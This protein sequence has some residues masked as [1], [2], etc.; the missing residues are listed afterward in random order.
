MKVYVLLS[1]I[2]FFI[3]I[4]PYAQA[5]SFL[6]PVNEKY[7]FVKNIGWATW[8]EDTVKTAE[9]T[10]VDNRDNEQYEKGVKNFDIIVPDFVAISK[11]KASFANDTMSH[12]LIEITSSDQYDNTISEKADGT[13]VLNLSGNLTKFNVSIKSNEKDTV[14]YSGKIFLKN[15][16]V[17]VPIPIDIVIQHDVNELI[18]VNLIGIAIGIG[19][20]V[21]IANVLWKDKFKLTTKSP[22]ISTTLIVMIGIPSSVYVNT[23]FIGNNALDIVIAFAVGVIVFTKLI[24]PQDKP[25]NEKEKERPK[26]KKECC[27]SWETKLKNEMNVEL[28]VNNI[29]DCNMK[30]VLKRSNVEITSTVIFPNESCS[31]SNDKID[32]IEW[33]SGQSVKP[34]GKCKYTFNL[35][36]T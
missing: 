30:I 14:T 1:V 21:L 7:T 27:A 2:F 35:T 6:S 5:E 11:G 36:I 33:S 25:K 8:W 32:T 16:S 10:I 19:I 15:E 12:R 29:G 26:H 20:A 34:Q 17:L 28:E 23:V 18:V 24:A 13:K 31:V 3:V 22:W 9:I 4:I